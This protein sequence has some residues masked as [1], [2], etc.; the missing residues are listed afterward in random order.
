MNVLFIIVT[1]WTLLRFVDSRTKES[2]IDHEDVDSGENGNYTTAELR[3]RVLA[4]WKGKTDEIQGYFD[5]LPSEEFKENSEDLKFKYYYER[6]GLRNVNTNQVYNITPQLYHDPSG[7]MYTVEVNDTYVPKYRITTSEEE[8]MDK[9]GTFNSESESSEVSSEE[10]KKKKKKK[11]K[12]DSS[13]DG[14]GKTKKKKEKKTWPSNMDPK[15]KRRKKKSKTSEEEKKKKDL[16]NKLN[17]KSNTRLN[18]KRIPD[19]NNLQKRIGESIPHDV[20][21]TIQGDNKGKRVEEGKQQQSKKFKS[22]Q[23]RSNLKSNYGIKNMQTKKGEKA[24]D[25][26]E[27]EKKLDNLERQKKRPRQQINGFPLRPFL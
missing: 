26:N 5:Q 25:N 9:Y 8:R 10:V 13:E 19:G 7:P 1:C 21:K 4:E 3:D 6:K 14:G 12:K 20:L 22:K 23:S 17:G 11:K 24:I 18:F 15:E 2:E 27:I 16:Q